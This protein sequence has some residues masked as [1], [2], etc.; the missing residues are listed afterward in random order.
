MGAA[1][2]NKQQPK[3]E[4]MSSNLSCL[5]KSDGGDDGHLPDKA[6]GGDDC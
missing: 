2:Q 4:K 1:H 6:R 3:F 5:I